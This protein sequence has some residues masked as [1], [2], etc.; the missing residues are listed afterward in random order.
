MTSQQT[1][2]QLILAY[3]LQTCSSNSV[4]KNGKVAPFRIH[5]NRKQRPFRRK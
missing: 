2:N 4:D 5:Q 3:R 1:P